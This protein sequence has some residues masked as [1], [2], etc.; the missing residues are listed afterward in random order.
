MF[1]E[2]YPGSAYLGQAGAIGAIPAVSPTATE[3]R[4]TLAGVETQRV[5]RELVTIRDVLNDAPNTCTL[6]FA[7]AALVSQPLRVSL[8]DGEHVLFAGALQNTNRTYVAGR[9]ALSTW[10]ASAIDDTARANERRPF[11]T[12]TN[13]SASTVAAE[14]AARVAPDF[15]TAIEAGLPSVTITYDGTETLIAALVRL[16]T[17]IGG[18]AKV[19]HNTIALFT[20]DPSD[21]PD[22]IDLAHPPLN[23]PPIQI[24]VD[25]SQLR[26]RVY[27]KGY[28]EQVPSDVAAGE[29]IIPLADGAQFTA[30]GG[31]AITGTTADGAQHQVIHY[32]SVLAGAG[33]TLV[34]IGASPSTGPTV[35]ITGGAGI[36]SGDHDWAYVYVTALGKSRPSPL[37]RRTIGTLDPPPTAPAAAAPSSGGG[38][39]LGSH[40][41]YPVF[42]TPGGR[43]TAGPPSNAITVTQVAPPSAIGLAQNGDGG[44]STDIVPG[45]TYWY[46]YSFYRPADGAETTLSTQWAGIVANAFGSAIQID[47]NGCNTPPAG[48]RRRWY[49][50][51]ANG[52]HLGPYRRV[53]ENATEGFFFGREYQAEMKFMEGTRDSE[54]QNAEPTVNTT[55]TGTCALTAIPVS[56]LT[57][58]THVDLYR[59]FNGAGAA[60]AK[61]ALSVPN[62]T[63]SA[64]DTAANASLG[65][66]V[67]AT[68]TAVANNAYVSWPAGPANVTS[69]ELYRTPLGST[70]LKRFFIWSGNTSNT[71]LD[72]FPDASLG[73]NAP[74]DDTSG[75]TSVA[76]QVNPGAPVVPVASASPF[77]AGGGWVRLGQQVVRYGSVSGNTLA[78]IPAFGPG[79]IATAILYGQQATPLPALVDV[80]G[81]VL[82]MARGSAVHVWV[83]RDD[84]DA[85]AAHAARAGG[86]GIVEYV[87]TDT[88]RAEPSL[89]ARCD[90]ELALFAR[91]LLTVT[92]ATRDIKTRSGKLVTIDL[93]PL[94][95]H[96]TLIIQD[97][98][99]T[100]IGTA[101][102]TDPRFTVKA[103]SV[104]FSLEDTLRRLV[105]VAPSVQR[106]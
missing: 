94:Q 69:I 93:P 11:G 61:L 55:K 91:P 47:L 26:T 83:Q 96:D 75:L 84:L 88:R 10:P 20:S 66:L 15:A 101:A 21:P 1:G 49:R 31:Q 51:V 14:L 19:E 7:D 100:E 45:A 13:V 102:H 70:Q 33:G 5:R 44:A 57:L 50:T 78:G 3:P 23:D 12:W 4:F 77:R 25:V 17:L 2:H 43:T 103:S 76:G 60:T 24:A 64:T 106:S 71:A 74:V 56:P 29:S 30:T 48:F 41:Y 85:Q 92:Y 54:L 72:N 37:A 68:N 98:T 86:T 81:L 46:R 28:G 36:E 82:P 38:L 73:I 42:R 67:P 79:A 80:T 40:R 59:E 53:A 99:I 34:G 90:A 87:F 104:R 32:G 89:V 63:T 62:G 58:V 16:A 97:V 22:P 18:Y 9:P 8:R 6:T 65:A 52:S 105:A 35:T 95:A 39:D 27:G